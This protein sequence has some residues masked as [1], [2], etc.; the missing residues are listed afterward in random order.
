MCNPW[1]SREFLQKIEKIPDG[2]C[3]DCLPD[4]SIT[5]YDSEISSAPIKPCDHTNLQASKL[6]QVKSVTL[7][8]NINPPPFVHDILSQYKDN[9]LEIPQ[10]AAEIK[11]YSNMRYRIK[12]SQI[13]HAVFRYKVKDKPTYNAF[14]EDIAIINFYFDKSYILQYTRHESMTMAGYISQLGGLLGLFIGFSF[15]SGVELIYWFTIRLFK[16]HGY[17]EEK[18][19]PPEYVTKFASRVLKNRS[20]EDSEKEVEQ[21]PGCDDKLETQSIERNSSNELSSN[22]FDMLFK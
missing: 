14:E 15:I 1:E 7:K 4:C 19:E 18:D 21:Q 16:N 10:F 3:E 11:M 22:A 6:C 12:E 13:P 5:I 2:S 8:Q 9:S 20:P 17:I